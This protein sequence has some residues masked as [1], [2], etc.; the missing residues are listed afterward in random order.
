MSERKVDREIERGIFGIVDRIDCPLR[1]GCLLARIKYRYDNETEQ[2]LG[3]SCGT[4]IWYGQTAHGSL[5]PPR[6]F[7]NRFKQPITCILNM[8]TGGSPGIG[9]RLFLPLPLPARIAGTRGKRAADLR[10]RRIFVPFVAGCDMVRDK[11]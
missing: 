2:N 5:V 3:V 4:S 9:E 11:S 10:A 7:A 8:T 6:S 1:D